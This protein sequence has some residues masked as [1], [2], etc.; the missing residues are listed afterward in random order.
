MKRSAMGTAA[1]AGA[2]VGAGL[3]GCAST[4]WP[5]KHHEVRTMVLPAQGGEVSIVAHSP[6]GGL[7]LSAHGRPAP[8]WKDL[9]TD[10]PEAG[11]GEVGLVAILRSDREDRLA[12]AELRPVWSGGTLTLDV[13]WPGHKRDREGVDWVVRVPAVGSVSGG[14]DFGDV[15]I[16]EP[17]GGVDLEADFGDVTIVRAHGPVRLEADFGDVEVS[18]TDENPGPVTITSDFGDVSLDA[19]PAFAGLLDLQTDFGDARL[20]QPGT[21]RSVHNSASISA[22]LGSGPASRIEADFG[23]VEVT[24]RQ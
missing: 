6:H 16:V 9:E 13:E 3:G 11:L 15:V 20:I 14:F 1:V 21:G 5:P 17:L 8:D 19:G 18:L 12:L 24:I 10:L 4:T 22:E 23:D 2:A 7:D